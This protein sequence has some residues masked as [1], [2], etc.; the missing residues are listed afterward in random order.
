MSS[1]GLSKSA[2][3]K[4]IRKLN[5]MVKDDYVQKNLPKL[6]KDDLQKS[7][8][9]RFSKESDSRGLVWYKP[10]GDY[11][12][13]PKRLADGM[14]QKISPNWN[15]MIRSDAKKN[16][17]TEAKAKKEKSAVDIIVD[18]KNAMNPIFDKKYNP[19]SVVDRIDSKKDID[20]INKEITIIQKKVKE[21][22]SKLKTK[23]NESEAEKSQLQKLQEKYTNRLKSVVKSM[24]KGASFL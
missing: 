8:E 3:I 9:R 13:L 15:K 24:K 17:A 22:S 19:K 20:D 23:G 21:T 4:H 16:K 2:M 11:D 6:T 12:V 5:I 7:F 18:L 1:E 14:W 10:K